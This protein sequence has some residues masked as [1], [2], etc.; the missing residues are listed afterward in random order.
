MPPGKRCGIEGR[1]G[2]RP[3]RISPHFRLLLR[4]C[5]PDGR[6]E[7]QERADVTIPSFTEPPAIGGTA[8]DL[9]RRGRS[10]SRAET[11]IQ[12]GRTARTVLHPFLERLERPSCA[13]LR[14]KLRLSS[15]RPRT[16]S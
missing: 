1:F 13:I 8:G 2:P 9:W 14:R 6:G 15:R 7:A 3:L 5:V 16:A 11:A 10:S 4:T 12:L